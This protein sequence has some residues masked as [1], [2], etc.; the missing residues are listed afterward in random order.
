[1]TTNLTLIGQFCQQLS[2][3]L[4]KHIA[5]FISKMSL[6]VHST[7]VG[8]QVNTKIGD[9]DHMLVDWYLLIFMPG[10]EDVY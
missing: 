3:C 5:Q 7:C 4:I 8:L 10:K 6:L 1:M 2:R 9:H